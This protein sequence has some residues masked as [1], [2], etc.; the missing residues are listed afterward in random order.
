MKAARVIES[1]GL[2]VVKVLD[3]HH[4]HYL[5]I[6]GSDKLYLIITTTRTLRHPKSL[7]INFDGE[8]LGIRKQYI[9]YYLMQNVEF[10]I[11]VIGNKALKASAVDVRKLVSMLGTCIKRGYEVICHYPVAAAKETL[12]AEGLE[13]WLYAA[14]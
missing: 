11:W 1:L 13:K 12:L 10:V 6:D 14:H 9:D 2:R 3:K 7:G 8:M 5:A 4:G